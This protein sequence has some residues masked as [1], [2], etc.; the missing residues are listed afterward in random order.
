MTQYPR[1]NPPPLAGEG[2]LPAPRPAHPTRV[3][4]E[5]TIAPL[6][7]SLPRKRGR[8]GVGV[9]PRRTNMRGGRPIKSRARR[10]RSN[11]TEAERA[12]WRELR[13]RQLGF[14]FRRQFPIPPYI[15]D[16]ACLEARLIVEVDG[17]QHSRPGDHD[18][19]DATLQ[20]KGWCVLRL[21]NNEVL[22]NLSGVLEKI[23]DTLGPRSTD[24]HPDPPPLAG[25]GV[26]V[27]PRLPQVEA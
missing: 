3:G 14:R 4:D 21:W 10:L 19:R 11:L 7:R 2:V 15:V 25:E 16:F 22:E 12:L 5:E 27:A 18:R 1:P 8:V 9:I 24:P 13:H 6:T 23:A 26:L 20:R 17:G